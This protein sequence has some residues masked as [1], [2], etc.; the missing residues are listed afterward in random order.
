MLIFYIKAIC[1]LSNIK[2]SYDDKT[3][4]NIINLLE[5]IYVIYLRLMSYETHY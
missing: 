5:N 1:D 3:Y 2:V 4:Y